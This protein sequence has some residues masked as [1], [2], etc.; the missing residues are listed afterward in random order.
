MDVAM[1]FS[2]ILRFTL[3]SGSAI[4]APS[5]LKL[6]EL[7]SL[8]GKAENQYFGYITPV[9][10]ALP[11]K[12]TDEICWVIGSCFQGNCHFRI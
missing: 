6:R 8:K 12:R 4:S 3:P 11:R 5:F 1:V 2:Q 10:A 9:G 7:V